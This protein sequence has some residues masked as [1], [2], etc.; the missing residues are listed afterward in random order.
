MCIRVIIN[1]LTLEGVGSLYSEPTIGLIMMIMIRVL[2][3]LKII[4]KIFLFGWIQIS[5]TGGKSYSLTS[6]YKATK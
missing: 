4:Y 3:F 5:P 1:S 2:C 6:P